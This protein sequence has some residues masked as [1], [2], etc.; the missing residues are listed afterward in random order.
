[1]LN[2]F[3]LRIDIKFECVLRMD[4]LKSHKYSVNKEKERNLGC[5]RSGE[6]WTPLYELTG[7]V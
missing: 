6:S 1:M 5:L 3:C 2:L 4:K 7:R